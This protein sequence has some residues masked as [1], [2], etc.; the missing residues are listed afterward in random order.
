MASAP[1]VGQYTLYTKRKEIG[2]SCLVFVLSCQH[3]LC[4]IIG[5]FDCLHALCWGTIDS[6]LVLVLC[7]SIVIM[8]F[9]VLPRTSNKSKK[10]PSGRPVGLKI[11]RSLT[12]ITKI[13]PNF[14]CL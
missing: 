13:L 2:A 11:L 3:L 10:Y 4:L 14:T 12:T 6:S 7:Y 8:V 1:Y 5:S 9:T